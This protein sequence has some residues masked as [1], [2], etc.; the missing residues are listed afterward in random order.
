MLI[1]FF[2]DA[3]FGG[4]RATVILIYG[5]ELDALAALLET[6]RS[7]ALAHNRQVSLH[8]LPGVHGIGGCRVSVVN[9][10]GTW[11]HPEGVYALQPRGAFRWHRDSEGW[12]EVADKVQSLLAAVTAGESNVYQVLESSKELAVIMSDARAW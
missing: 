2:A 3:D 4:G 1:E 10:R 12:L 8:D 6:F 9:E 11:L 7:V 5:R